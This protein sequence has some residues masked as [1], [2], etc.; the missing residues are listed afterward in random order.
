SQISDPVAQASD[1]TGEPAHP[2]QTIGAP[3][4]ATRAQYAGLG[5]PRPR[6]LVIDATPAHR[7][8]A[9]SS[10]EVAAGTSLDL[11]GRPEFST[12]LGG[13]VFAR[14]RYSSTLGQDLLVVSVPIVEDSTT[15]GG[16][17]R[18]VGAL[19]ISEPL[20]DLNRT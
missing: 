9:D 3:V 10:N 14:P 7:V 8:L 6:V 12:A 18:V 19:R 15:P 4:E 13:T 17:A 20:T 5:L 11:T 1:A 2:G 16:A